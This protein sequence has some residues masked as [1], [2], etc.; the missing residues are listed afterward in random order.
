MRARLSSPPGRPRFVSTFRLD[1]V[2]GYCICCTFDPPEVK[3]LVLH[4]VQLN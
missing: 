2:T 1:D 4:V 3:P